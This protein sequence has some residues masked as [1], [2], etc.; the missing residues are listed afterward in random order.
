MGPLRSKALHCSVVLSL[1]SLIS[2]QFRFVDSSNAFFG[3]DLLAL[4]VV[5]D[6]PVAAGLRGT[7]LAVFSQRI[8]RANGTYELRGVAGLPPNARLPSVSWGCT[9]P[10]ETTEESCRI[11]RASRSADGFFVA[12]LCSAPGSQGNVS[13]VLISANGTAVGTGPIALPVPACG[14]AADM[15]ADG[16]IRLWIAS[17]GGVYSARASWLGVETGLLAPVSVDDPPAGLPSLQLS[18]ARNALALTSAPAL[19]SPTPAVEI[20]AHR[21]AATAA[22]SVAPL[23]L[24]LTS[25]AGGELLSLDPDTA[26][27]ASLAGVPGMARHAFAVHSNAASLLV[28]TAPPPAPDEL[29]LPATPWLAVGV[30][31]GVPGAELRALVPSSPD[32]SL[33]RDVAS[34]TMN[35]QED[36]LALAARAGRPG[37]TYTYR[38]CVKLTQS[39]CCGDGHTH[40]WTLQ[41]NI[42]HCTIVA[43]CTPLTCFALHHCRLRTVLGSAVDLQERPVLAAVFGVTRS[44]L[45]RFLFCHDVDFGVSAINS[46]LQYAMPDSRALRAAFTGIAL[47]PYDPGQRLPGAPGPG[48]SSSPQPTR[49]ASES[50]TGTPAPSPSVGADA[51]EGT[52]IPTG[53]RLSLPGEIGAVVKATLL[54]LV[55]GQQLPPGHPQL[56]NISLARPV[57]VWRVLRSSGALDVNISMTQ[58]RVV[59]PPGSAITHF[60]CAQ[61]WA[62]LPS[63]QL[64]PQFLSFPCFDAAPMQDVIVPRDMLLRFPPRPYAAFQHLWPTPAASVTPAV[65]PS[66]S[67]SP[68]AAASPAA[69]PSSSALPLPSGQAVPRSPHRAVAA[70]VFR[71]GAVDTSTTIYTGRDSTGSGSGS[72]NGDGT[73]AG[74]MAATYVAGEPAGLFVGGRR[75]PGLLNDEVP[76]ACRLRAVRPGSSADRP[77]LSGHDAATIGGDVPI[78]SN[79]LKQIVALNDEPQVMQAFRIAGDR[80]D[81]VDNDFNFGADGKILPLDAIPT[82]YPTLASWITDPLLTP[83]RP[84][85]VRGNTLTSFQGS[86]TVSIATFGR[87]G[88][89]SLWEHRIP[90]DSVRGRL[91]WA[92]NPP[93]NRTIISLIGVNPELA[94]VADSAAALIQ[95]KILLVSTF[96]PSDVP[97]RFARAGAAI[98]SLALS[99]T[100]PSSVS[101]SSFSLLRELPC[102]GLA[103]AGI[104]EN[105]LQDAG[106]AVGSRSATQTATASASRTASATPSASETPGAFA[107]RFTS[108]PASSASPAATS[109]PTASAA[110]AGSDTRNSRSTCRLAADVPCVAAEKAPTPMFLAVKDCSA[111]VL[112]LRCGSS[113]TRVARV[114]QPSSLTTVACAPAPRGA[115]QTLPVPVSVAAA[116]FNGSYAA[117][118]PPVLSEAGASVF[119]SSSV[120]ASL[121]T[122]GSNASYAAAAAL[123][124]NES[125]SNSTS[126]YWLAHRRIASIVCVAAPAATGDSLARVRLV[127]QTQAG[128]SANLQAVGVPAGSV[129]AQARAAV[130]THSGVWPLLWDFVAFL[131]SRREV[132][133]ARSGLKQAVAVG[134]ADSAR[135]N[136]NTSAAAGMATSGAAFS[137]APGLELA[138]AHLDPWNVTLAQLQA[139]IVALVR[140]TASEPMRSASATVSDAALVT[141]VAFSAPAAYSASSSLTRPGATAATQAAVFLPATEVAVGAGIRADVVAISGDGQLLHFFTPSG[142]CDGNVGATPGSS[143]VSTAASQANGTGSIVG[144]SSSDDG[145]VACDAYSSLTISTPTPFGGRMRISMPP[146][147]FVASPD[148]AGAPGSA[149]P[150]AI[151]GSPSEA[152]SAST[153]VVPAIVPAADSS[154]DALAEAAAAVAG[155]PGLSR[156]GPLFFS[157]VCPGFTDPRTGA[158]ADPSA[159]GFASCAFGSGAAC[160]ACPAECICRGGARCHPRPGFYTAST[161]IPAAVR[162]A[163]PAEQRCLGWDEALGAVRCGA[164]YK[165]GSV[166]CAACAAGLYLDDA[167]GECSACPADTSP[168]ALVLRQLLLFLGVLLAITATLAV[169][170]IIIARCAGG[171]MRGSARRLLDLGLWV[172]LI[173]QQLAAVSQ[174][175]ATSLPPFLRGVYAVLAASQLQ[176]AMPPSACLLGGRP[177][178]LELAL[179]GFLM[180]LTALVIAGVVFHFR[181]QARYGPLMPRK[182]GRLSDGSDGSLSASRSRTLPERIRRWCCRTAGCAGSNRAADGRNAASTGREPASLRQASASAE[183]LDRR[184]RRLAAT[185]Q[186]G[187]MLMALLYSQATT[188]AFT[189]LSCV[190]V[191]MPYADALELNGADESPAVAAGRAVLAT[192]ILTGAP[193]QPVTV[194]VLAAAPTFLCG[195][196]AHRAVSALAALTLVY[197]SL[198]LPLIAALFVVFRAPVLAPCTCCIRKTFITTLAA[199]FACCHIGAGPSTHAA[200]AAAADVTMKSQ[201]T[202]TPKGEASSGN[203]ASPTSGRSGRRTMVVAALPTDPVLAF[204]SSGD[205][206][207]PSRFY[208]RQ[209]DMAGLAVLAAIAV[210]WRL[211]ASATAAAWKAALVVAVLT[212]AGALVL[213]QQP[214]PPGQGWKL[215]IRIASLVVGALVAVLNALLAVDSLAVGTSPSASS[216]GSSS[217]DVP[218]TDSSSAATRGMTIVVCCAVVAFLALLVVMVARE[219]IRSAA[220]ESP[221]ASL[222][223]QAAAAA[224]TLAQAAALRLASRKTPST[225]VAPPRRQTMAAPVAT[226]SRLRLSMTAAAPAAAATASS[227]PLSPN[228]PSGSMR[229]GS[230]GGGLSDSQISRL[231]LAAVPRY[232]PAPAEAAPGNISAREPHH[233]GRL[234]EGQGRGSPSGRGRIPSFHPGVRRSFAESL[235][236]RLQGGTRVGA[237]VDATDACAY[238]DGGGAGALTAEQVRSGWRLRAH[239]GIPAMQ[240]GSGHHSHHL[241][242]AADAVAAGAAAGASGGTA[243]ANARS[244]LAGYWDAAG[245]SQA[246]S[247][248]GS[249]THAHGAGGARG[250]RSSASRP[251]VTGGG[252]RLRAHDAAAAQ[253]AA[254]LADRHSEAQDIFIAT[255]PLAPGGQSRTTAGALSHGNLTHPT[256]AW[257]RHDSVSASSTD[258]A[259]RTDAPGAPALASSATRA[260]FASATFKPQV[261]PR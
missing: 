100:D 255:N 211:P 128:V 62:T 1:L 94:F 175:A 52:G 119:D 36:V 112:A 133:S 44:T 186:G 106:G 95:Y 28:S 114:V 29:P 194:S 152:T 174:G 125:S 14:V 37:D 213:V 180:C 89:A 200:K 39:Q 142:I 91:T 43:P 107:L 246:R 101:Q 254:A 131:P 199:V 233:E 201:Q 53:V 27:T 78:L 170:V 9:I 115:W 86:A 206:Y 137:W 178:A 238:D 34:F 25:A 168:A 242:D 77:M 110:A 196:G 226:A 99:H 3:T 74:L 104:V 42:L 236:Q 188:R 122:T 17:M 155:A 130:A 208:H 24:W 32:L 237:G 217:G 235:R 212:A 162:C 13:V 22:G 47:A 123:L 251:S 7:E 225:S 67:A 23:Q 151:I 145:A 202:E 40:T 197:Y 229:R 111:S 190:T 26:V 141:A 176:G 195:L 218:A 71:A 189:A 260:S 45:R 261:V 249:V 15:G 84:Y 102:C 163:A 241:D 50:V 256:G 191:Q 103:V 177:F 135:G 80:S 172:V 253:L 149:V 158:C 75:M 205:P 121:L 198:L 90:A 166:G 118:A 204:F 105:G 83:S 161:S 10:Y 124:L 210:F 192:A 146:F 150:L 113:D 76:L 120:S 221:A 6:A 108:A 228:S 220:A 136:A 247:G 187:V 12:V 139:A 182:S 148:A 66:R 171:T 244:L 82:A 30:V 117:G 51:A 87:L 98:W 132:V 240:R 153:A 181:L 54:L 18:I 35:T 70:L 126:A 60:R 239:G 56:A 231:N 214:Y 159:P 258:F 216:S 179:F 16:T 259:G 165:Q 4:T 20:T 140:R 72:A 109:T 154:F 73:C 68:S 227:T 138:R 63:L 209:A 144:A 11:G 134:G 232:A 160:R 85:V 183:A 147:S 88:N 223:A 167:T 156:T 93:D 224:S 234:E 46:V 48:A 55:V 215:S 252:A 222:A 38:R 69:L 127:G 257:H 49:S 57:A 157:S 243:S 184:R 169:I 33:W 92:L 41:A 143:G 5:S 58:Q 97:E 79:T 207:R 81:D 203:S 31:P 8:A 245:A 230:W 59:Y 185:V 96:E 116:F 21:F 248:R 65:S 61:S 193:P 64:S 250:A 2:F 19:L 129:A 164:T 219:L 173:V